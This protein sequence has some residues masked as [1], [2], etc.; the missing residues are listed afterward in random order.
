MSTSVSDALQLP[1]SKKKQKS[2]DKINE[3]ITL[4]KQEGYTQDIIKEF[5]IEK[6]FDKNTVDTTVNKSF[7]KS[8]SI[9]SKGKESR[10][11]VGL[12]EAVNRIRVAYNKGSRDK[13]KAIQEA[14]AEAVKFVF[15]KLKTRVNTNELKQIIT[16]VRDI[17]DSNFDKVMDVLDAAI[18]KINTKA[19]EGQYQTQTNALIK[20]VKKRNKKGE[21]AINNI[22][23]MR[24]MLSRI[25]SL[26]ANEIPS[27]IRDQYKEILSS[28]VNWK[29]TGAKPLFDEV[30]EMNA[31]L[32]DAFNNKDF[33]EAVK[34]EIEL[35]LMDEIQE[36]KDAKEAELK[37][38]YKEVISKLLKIGYNKNDFSDFDRA[39]LF[40]LHSFLRKANLDNL[41][42]K[43]LK[44]IAQQLMQTSK[45]SNAWMPTMEV[46]SLVMEFEAARVVEGMQKEVFDKESKKISAD[47]DGYVKTIGKSKKGIDAEVRRFDRMMKGYMSSFSGLFKKSKFS[48]GETIGKMVAGVSAVDSRKAQFSRTFEGLLRKIK[49]NDYDNQLKLAL[50]AIEKR[51]QAN[52]NNKNVFSAKEHIEATKKDKESNNEDADHI[53]KIFDKWADKNGEIDVAKIEES[54]TPAEKKLVDFINIEQSY[55]NERRKNTSRHYEGTT[56]EDIDWYTPL[57]VKGRSSN[58]S[59][60]LN[61]KV[62]SNEPSA[63][64]SNK[65]LS[66]NKANPI[67]LDYFKNI[68]NHVVSSI[69]YEV[70]MPI[71]KQLEATEKAMAQS[72]NK[73]ITDWK[74]IVFG[75]N[76][77][78]KGII[79]R[80]IEESNIQKSRDSEFDKFLGTTANNIMKFLLLSVPRLVVDATINQILSKGLYAPAMAKGIINRRKNNSGPKIKT[81]VWMSELFSSYNSEQSERSLGQHTTDG[82]SVQKGLEEKNSYKTNNRTVFQYINDIFRYNVVNRSTDRALEMY[83]SLSDQPSMEIWRAS[84]SKEFPTFDIGA[85]MGKNK[86]DYREKY[87]QQIKDAI[88]KA[89]SDTKTLFNTPSSAAEMLVA[90]RGKKKGLLGQGAHLLLGFKYNE[91]HALRESIYSLMPNFIT[92]KGQLNTLE[93]AKVAATISSRA[94]A[95]TAAQSILGAMIVNAFAPPDE[96]DE[97]R[98]AQILPRSFAQFASFTVLGSQNA[99]VTGAFE[100]VVDKIRESLADEPEDHQDLFFSKNPDLG[101][102]G[103]LG[104]MIENTEALTAYAWEN[105]YMTEILGE[106]PDDDAKNRMIA[107]KALTS[108]V[109][110]TTGVKLKLL[111]KVNNRII[112]D[113]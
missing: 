109:A 29:K 33:S 9:K 26:S 102:L 59:E 79:R 99:Y 31:A 82:H 51:N 98:M 7:A 60:S 47:I 76:A 18:D 24:V 81:D 17:K 44:Q 85:F 43:K 88:K 1:L 67:S 36:K 30:A 54:M 58:L 97:E 70:M 50:Y 90:T 77:Q 94:I 108:M 4:A 100:M 41:N 104:L 91:H 5:L 49:G 39:Q 72:D 48:Y 62:R 10:P 46:T 45:G 25:T 78:D 38:Q 55:A 27:D 52:P 13:A 21:Y 23:E 103:M 28:L 56:A 32:E 22:P 87:D 66:A 93:A 112:R 16:K 34:A 61:I 19:E 3:I 111:E 96:E 8:V 6:G 57:V 106:E 64:S 74:R 71:F 113:E 53:Q 75:G 63:G 89:D 80:Q 73:A 101:D 15:E 105:V 20:K 95:Y 42:S 2:K 40:K 92:K 69:E 12:K 83:Y 110:L 84:F 35:S 14:K 37:E 11:S 68:K 65:T 107:N 86:L